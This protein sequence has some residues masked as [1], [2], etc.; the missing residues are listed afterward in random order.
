MGFFDKERNN[1]K[2]F[3]HTNI[4]G[5]LLMM[6]KGESHRKALGRRSV[7]CG[8][9]YRAEQNAAQIACLDSFQACLWASH[10]LMSLNLSLQ[11]HTYT[12]G[13]PQEGV[14][15]ILQQNYK[16]WCVFSI[17]ISIQL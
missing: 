8:A 7:L 5:Q 17:T 16:W 15:I 1:S 9:G 13:K 4:V 11:G 6:R 12:A 14:V 3:C 2:N 10:Y